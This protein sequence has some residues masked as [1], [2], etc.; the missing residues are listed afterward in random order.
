MRSA[1]KKLGW[2]SARR[3]LKIIQKIKSRVQSKPLQLH[4]YFTRISTTHSTLSSNFWHIVRRSLTLSARRN[5]GTSRARMTFTT[6]YPVYYSFT[7]SSSTYR[8]NSGQNLQLWRCGHIGASI[9]WPGG[10]APLKSLAYLVILRSVKRRTKQN[11]V[12]RLKS[13]I[14]SSKKIWVGYG[15][16]WAARP[17]L[18]GTEGRWYAFGFETPPKWLFRRN[19]DEDVLHWKI[20]NGNNLVDAIEK[21]KMPVVSHSAI[22]MTHLILT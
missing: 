12:V 19:S 20:S 1:M 4:C 9:G 11:T 14:F 8:N 13:N 2:T 10:H 17:Q 5:Y 16:A 18:V 15:T 7:V 22:I 3:F 21:P 6:K